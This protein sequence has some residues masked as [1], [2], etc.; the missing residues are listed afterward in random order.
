MY[1]VQESLYLRSTETKTCVLHSSFYELISLSS[2]N[3]Y[4]DRLLVIQFAAG[5]IGPCS[6]PPIELRSVTR[7]PLTRAVSGGLVSVRSLVLNRTN[8]KIQLRLSGRVDGFTDQE[9]ARDV[10]IAPKSECHFDMLIRVPLQTKGSD[11]IEI[12]VDAMQQR[13]GNF[14][15]L[16]LMASR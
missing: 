4:V 13:G 11:R 5:Q 7:T 15:Q 3:H 12:V 16:E 1:L 10:E 8:D 2:L 6:G 14:Y 9:Q